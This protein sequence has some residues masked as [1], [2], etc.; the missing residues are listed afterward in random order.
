[1][2]QNLTGSEDR[3]VEGDA[4]PLLS[5]TEGFRFDG[6]DGVSPFRWHIVCLAGRLAGIRM[7]PQYLDKGPQILVE[8]ASSPRAHVDES[9]VLIGDKPSLIEFID[10]RD[11]LNTA[12][13]KQ[14][15]PAYLCRRESDFEV[16]PID[17]FFG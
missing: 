15:Q 13:Q 17:P 2:A 9:I 14:A 12:R 10:G 7:P 3:C 11:P 8:G 16:V 6:H 5:E 1:M 4:L